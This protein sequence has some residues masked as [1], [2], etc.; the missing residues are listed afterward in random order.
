MKTSARDLVRNEVKEK[1]SRNELVLS[2]AVRLVRTVEIA[3]IAS[4]AGFD[5]LYI[6]LEHNS[7]SVDTAG[8]ICMA[9][10][11]VGVTP[12]VRVPSHEHIPRVLDGGAL[13][14][15]APH[16]ESPA[17][18]A[19]IV[20]AAK[21]PPLGERSIAGNLPHFG[22]RTLPAGDVVAALN[23]ATMV[24]VMIESAEALDSVEEIAA[25]DGVDVLFIGTNDLCASLGI[26]G[27]LDHA[28]VRD[29]YRRCA[30]ACSKNGKHLGVGGLAAH[31]KL[32]AQLIQLGARYVSTGTD[33]SFLLSAAT[34]K[35]KQMQEL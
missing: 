17:D 16:V 2:M 13:G 29:A 9:A 22:F 15:I 26:P 6:D 8:Q 35:V 14:V 3:S 5:S 31:P 11:A 24:I 33:L 1:L 20:R 7:F 21:F 10:L 27:Q 30:E 19:K 32:T 12:F 28:L 25:V 23:D 18:A 34:A 4:A